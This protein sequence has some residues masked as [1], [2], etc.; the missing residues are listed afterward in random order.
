MTIKLK[1]L[2]LKNLLGVALDQRST[3]TVSPFTAY[4]FW[5]KTDAWEQLRLEL[6]SKSWI[7]SEEKIVILNTIT[8]IIE[9]YNQNRNTKRI[10]QEIPEIEFVEVS[11]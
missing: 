6:E 3:T 8:D 7:K 1:V 4:Y 5:P 2:W 11:D 10:K 9:D